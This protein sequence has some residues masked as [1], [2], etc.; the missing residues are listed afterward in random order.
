MYNPSLA[1]RRVRLH[2]RD[3]LKIQATRHTLFG[4]AVS[5]RTIPDLTVEQLTSWLA[6][7][8]LIQEEL[9]H[10]PVVDREFLLTGLNPGEQL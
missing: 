10:L 3:A 1:Y 7:D 5:Y 8:G 4:G 2:G 6:G 9:G